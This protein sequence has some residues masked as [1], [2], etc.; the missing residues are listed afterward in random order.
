[1]PTFPDQPLYQKIKEDILRQIKDGQLL[2]G[3]KIPTEY[4]LMEKYGVSRITVSKALSEL[5]S[6]GI[7]TRFPHKGT[8]VTKSVLLPPLVTGHADPLFPYGHARVHDGNRL[9]SSVYHG[10]LFPVHG[11]RRPVRFPEDTYICHIFQSHNP[12]VEN[13]LLQ[14]CLELNISG[15]VL[16]PQDQPFF[17][18]QLLAMQLQNYPLVL[19]DRY[20]PRLNTNYVIADNKAAGELC[21]RHLHKL[22][23]QRIAFVTS[24]DR[25]TFSVK[26][27]IEG[28]QETALSLNLPDYAVQL[29]EFLDKHKKFSYYQDLFLNL[30]TQNRV[31]AFITAE[32]STCTY[33]YD[34]L[35]SL[36]IKVP[37]DV[38]LMSFD[39][40]VCSS[41][42]PDF[43]THIS[44]SEY[45][46]GREAGTLLKNR[47]ELYDINTYHRVITPTL[48]VHES[49]GSVCL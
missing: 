44:Q 21:L 35:T 43:F 40:P 17:S 49:T 22:G 29:V 32:S 48:H 41:R 45:L 19:L 33:L 38:S 24:T 2:P 42:N 36:D 6:E 3:D 16:F 25:N 13:Y 30:I 11:Q 15:I 31:T 8:F 28:I 47:I 46:M 18:N 12:T 27:R 4:Q 14:R 9:H 20:L 5:K 1:M 7:I 37:G 39:K 34:L 10:F 23:H 26:Y